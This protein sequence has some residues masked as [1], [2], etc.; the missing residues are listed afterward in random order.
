MIIG[1]AF[2]GIAYNGMSVIIISQCLNTDQASADNVHEQG[3]LK[4][5]LPQISCGRGFIA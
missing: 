1:I 3:K 5:Q 2:P 4:M